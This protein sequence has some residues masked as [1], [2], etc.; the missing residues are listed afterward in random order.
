MHEKL[1]AL[2][3]T[4]RSHAPLVIAYSGGVDSACLLAEAH[5]VLGSGMLGVIADSPSLPRQA[6]ADA[7]ALAQQIGAPL[8]VVQTAELENPDYAS[9]PVNRCYFCKAELFQRL[10][11]LAVARG[12]APSR[13]ARIRTICSTSAP[14]ARRRPS[15]PCSRRSGTPD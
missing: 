15:S 4:L 8:E 12:S 7:V 6:L 9:N 2:E 14:A 10:D 5:R 3:E 1:A 13:M 11:Q